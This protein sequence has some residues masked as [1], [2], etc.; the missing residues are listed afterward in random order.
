MRPRKELGLQSP[1]AAS[2]ATVRPSGMVLG[3]LQS[4]LRSSDS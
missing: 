1:S 2:L 3:I 4:P